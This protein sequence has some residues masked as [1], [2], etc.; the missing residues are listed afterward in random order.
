MSQHKIK[1][2]TPSKLLRLSLTLTRYQNG[3]IKDH[4]Y[5][6]HSLKNYGEKNMDNTV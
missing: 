3:L 2:W 5:M 1:H 4:E 6:K